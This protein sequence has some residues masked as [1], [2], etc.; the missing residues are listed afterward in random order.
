MEDQIVKLSE[1]L[2]DLRH[3]FI[4]VHTVRYQRKIGNALPH[5]EQHGVS[6]SWQ[7]LNSSRLEREKKTK[8]KTY[9]YYTYVYMYNDLIMKTIIPCYIA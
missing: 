7:I 6:K 3:H 1:F 8:K 5:Y 4:C 9:M 2:S